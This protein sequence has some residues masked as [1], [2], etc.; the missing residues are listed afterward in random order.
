MILWHPT[1]H[2]N[3]HKSPPMDVIRSKLNVIHIS[4]YHLCKLNFNI[5]ISCTFMCR[6]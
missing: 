6:K 5:I 2:R 1:G 4:T 3:V